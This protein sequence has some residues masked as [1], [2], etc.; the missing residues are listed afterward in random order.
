[1]NATV[2]TR[3]TLGDPGRR[4]IEVRAPGREDSRYEV[5]LTEGTTL[6]IT[7][8]LGPARP[9]PAVSSGAI[10]SAAVT[11]ADPAP[12]A[13]P[14]A[15]LGWALAGGGAAAL[16]VG[17]V[18]GLLTKNKWDEVQAN[19]DLVHGVCNDA[20]I[21]ASSAGQT[22]GTVSTA[23]FI[24]GG[25]SVAVGGYLLLTRKDA[26]A[27]ARVAATAGPGVVGLRLAGEF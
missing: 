14:S 16:G 12:T 6:E 9:E 10:A 15:T 25:V 13:A 11:A 18:T 26:P 23:A 27:T 3:G 2:F 5:T 21:R 7:V 24:V 17:V 20:G 1:M 19:C 4:I 8:G 22:L